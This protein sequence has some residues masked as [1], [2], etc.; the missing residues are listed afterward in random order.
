MRPVVLLRGDLTSDLLWHKKYLCFK[1]NITY[2]FM[3]INE[4]VTHLDGVVT[5]FAENTAIMP[6]L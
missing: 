2:T 6:L 5:H 4:I 1:I 3:N